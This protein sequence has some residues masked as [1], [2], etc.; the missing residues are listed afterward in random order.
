[1]GKVAFIFPGQG[2]QKIGMGKEI[3]ATSSA[4]QK[5]F[6]EADE[7]L[8]FSLSSLCF[9]GPEEKLTQTEI[10]Q[11]AILTTSVALL[12]ALKPFDITPDFVAGHSLG[13]YSALVAAGALTFREAVVAVHERGKWMEEAVPTGIGAMTAIMGLDREILDQICRDVSTTEQSVQPANYNCPGQ[14]VISGHQ[15]A[16][17]QAAKLAKEAGAR[18]TIS[19]TVSGP[20]H[21]KL[22]EPASKKLKQTL[23]RVNLQQASIP[24]VANVSASPIQAADE[25]RKALIDQVASPV[26]WEDIVRFLLEQGVDE[27]VEVGTGK[28]LAGLVRKID[29]NVKVWNVQDSASLQSLAESL[30]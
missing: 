5:V 18:R 14:I 8:G 13:E 20:F 17:D 30:K 19:L 25:I 16:V 3:A 26:L 12:E 1:M 9:E 23:D 21:S 7:A 6:A 11:P 15:A 10:T 24:V 28:V 4:A 22:M 27:M 29:R 2:S